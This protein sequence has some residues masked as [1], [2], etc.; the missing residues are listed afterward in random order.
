MLG[1]TIRIIATA[2]NP[3]V[4]GLSNSLP[5]FARKFGDVR[6]EMSNAI[7][8]YREEVISRKFPPEDMD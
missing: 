8:K 3:D 1:K 2:I 6:T 4:I 7:K 5:P